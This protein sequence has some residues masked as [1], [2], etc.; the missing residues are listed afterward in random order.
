M[1]DRDIFDQ[2]LSSLSSLQ[3]GD[4]CS[5]PEK[6]QCF[7]NKITDIWEYLEIFIPALLGSGYLLAYLRVWAQSI[8]LPLPSMRIVW[9]PGPADC[10][11]F[12][13]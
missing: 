1:F 7:Q 6:C 4:R 11:H 3:L 13:F 5:A 8:L 2:S 9:R 10:I 12:I